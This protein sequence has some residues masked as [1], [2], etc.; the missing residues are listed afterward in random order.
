MFFTKYRNRSKSLRARRGVSPEVE[1]EAL[2]CRRLLTAIIV[3][4]ADDTAT[5][6]GESLRDAITTANAD[7]LAG[8]SDTITFASGLN[9]DTI[10]L[11]QGDLELGQDGAGSGV[12]TINGANQIT[13]SGNNA[14]GV[15]LVD[16][17]VTFV[18]NALT[19]TDGNSNTLPGGA[20]YNKF[21][22]TGNSAASAVAGV[23][24][25]DG[26]MMVTDATF[27]G[28]SSGDA[29]GC[30]YNS[31]TMTVTNCTFSGNVSSDS[32]GAI[33]N[34]SAM[35]VTDC[36]FSGDSADAAGG[37]IDNA[38][39]GTAA[40]TNST[41]SGDGADYTGGGVQNNGDMTV[42]GSTFTGNSAYSGG[43][44]V[45]GGG[46]YS[47]YIMSVTNSTFTGNSAP[48]SGGYG[49]AIADFDPLTVANSTI[50]GNS[51]GDQGGGGIGGSEVNLLNC[52]VAGNTVSAGA[53]GPD[54]SGSLTS[55]S[56]FN[57]I[58][59]GTNMTGI[60]N[61][62]GGNIV[63]TTA[64]PILAGLLP[65][66]YNGGPTQTMALT[67]NSPAR[68][69]GGR[70]TS[71][72]SAV[73]ATATSIPV[74]L[75]SAIASTP[76]SYVIQVE[77]E[78]MLVTNVSGNN[79]IVTRGYNGTTATAHSLGAKVYLATD[80]TGAARGSPPDI[81]AYQ[82]QTVTSSV[83]PLPATEPSTSF[84]V[85]WTGTPGTEDYGV[86]NYSIYDS[87]ND[88]QYVLWKHMTTA[89]SG[90]F[91]GVNG[92]T[93]RFYSVATDIGGNVQPTPT[94]P[95]AIT[96]IDV[97]T[98][99]A[100]TSTNTDYMYV[101]ASSSF[102]V[103][104]SGYPAPTFNETGTLPA[105]V[106]FNT[107]TGVLS[108]TPAAG[109]VASYALTF[110]ASNGLGTPASQPFTLTVA[111]V[112]TKTTL[113]KNT[114]GPIKYGQSITFTAAVAPTATN[115]ITPTGTVTFMDGATAL[116][117]AALSGG[118][119]TFTTTAL[120]T[121]SHPSLTA[122][123]GGDGNFTTSAS[124]ALMQTVSQS[125]TTTK[126]TKSSTTVLKYGQSVTFTATLAAVSPGA[127][128]PTGIVT[129]FDNGSSIGAG[130][131]SGGIATL[132]TTTLPVGSNS[133]TAV[134][135]GDTN[136]TTSTTSAL[137]QTVN[138]SSTTTKL[139]KNTT[140]AITS[141]Q[142]VTFTATLAA[143]SPGAG[144][145]TGTV[146]FMDNGSSLG[147]ITL[148][149]GIAMLTTTTLPVGSNS[150]TAVYSG[151]TDF[152][153]STSGALSQTVDS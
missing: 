98:P 112:P 22:F 95:Q 134:Y 48:G 39:G 127:G 71:L 66:D 124:A 32:G 57:L 9:G 81:G 106:S 56:T 49:G 132:T 128:T 38:Q 75:P 121:G 93:Y 147:I 15:F 10:T 5:H 40:V 1:I 44:E 110:G 139:T 137:T 103:L 73:T 34:S 118:V 79:L 86:A 2:E 11:A 111:Q 52:I 115:S 77:N 129:F 107:A 26:T 104:A 126:L 59:D 76:G 18:C 55:G 120:S 30:I 136:F 35:T 114:T 100:I 60:S 64:T 153:T 150:I 72:T 8:T 6:T 25:N 90:T 61:G 146:D 4:T 141:G 13:V 78:Q 80:Q 122:V 130:T 109:S 68:H 113:T 46:I 19:I 143:V 58:G 50:S 51:A 27:S 91:T 135:G 36:T 70:V 116:G 28:N 82:Y 108:G 97:L 24:Y 37:A 7:A 96:T 12:I 102:T 142:S 45:G 92:H 125:A 99:P 41:F 54:I 83:N 117:T 84:T 67:A 87:D 42:A 149:G 14:S 47:D 23:V 53:E 3:T 140:T 31:N 148:S 145:P 16:S 17:G 21:T 94:S 105:G 123:Y 133:I 144:T 138:Q 152:T 63:G 20:I 131:L 88:G 33:Y 119:A 43:D 85:S 69:A 65:L 62:N 101:G 29:G 151:D 74:G 89:S